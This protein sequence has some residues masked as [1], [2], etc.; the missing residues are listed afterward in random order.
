MIKKILVLIM[1][2]VVGVATISVPVMADEDGS[3]TG[4]KGRWGRE[5]ANVLTRCAEADDGIQCLLQW[6]VD[7]L[8]VGVGVLAFIGISVSGVQY[9]TAGGSEEKTRKAKRRIF[10]IVIGLALYAIIYAI[11]KWLLPSFG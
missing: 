6:S 11:L 7:I 4:T 2:V 3:V 10:E 1:T 9:L 8:S 5:N